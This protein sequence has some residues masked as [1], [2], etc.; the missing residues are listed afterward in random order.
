MGKARKKP[1]FSTEAEERA[2]W[3]RQD[4]SGYVD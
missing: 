3:E 2:F 4:S 1:D